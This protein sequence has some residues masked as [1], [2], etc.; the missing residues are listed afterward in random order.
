MRIYATTLNLRADQGMS[1]V[2]ETVQRWVR[3]KERP[4]AKTGA[5]AKPLRFHQRGDSSDDLDVTK[6][7]ARELPSGAYLEVLHVGA[8]DGTALHSIRYSHRDAKQHG[9]R[10]VTEIGVRAE[11]GVEELQVS[12]YLYT[13]DLSARV[14]E[15]VA[16][17]RPTLVRDMLARCLPMPG[18]P[19]LSLETLGLA[20]AEAFRSRVHDANR[21]AP[22][23]VL[24]PA[25]AGEYLVDP[26]ACLDQLAGLADVVCIPPDEDTRRIEE[27]IGGGL[28][29]YGGAAVILFTPRGGPYSTPVPSR[30]FLPGTIESDPSDAKVAVRSLFLAI[31]ERTNL[32]NSKKHISPERVREARLRQALNIRLRDDSSAVQ[33]RALILELQSEIGRQEEEVR[34]KD[35]EIAENEDSFYHICDQLEEIRKEKHV[36]EAKNAW[37]ESRISLASDSPSANAE[38]LPELRTAIARLAADEPT[39][40]QCLTLLQ[41]F[42]PDRVCVLQSAFDSADAS[43]GFRSGSRLWELLT[44]LAEQYWDALAS[45]R[46]DDEARKVFP[47]AKFA[48]RDKANL[49]KA[50]RQARTFIYKQQPLFMEPHL[51]VGNNGGSADTTL[52]VHFEWISE[53]GLIVIGHCGE[54]I[55]F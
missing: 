37:L 53:D 1:R 48:A 31:T 33:L 10:W 19:G 17:S 16:P 55:S 39:P 26:A 8:S 23:V 49:S 32:A 27:V 22:I 41:H 47:P 54:H 13:D 30:R 4:G 51:K 40:R 43:V 45:G 29:P 25:T 3:T 2:L 9:R 46:P 20:N 11:A 5:A 6:S 14:A 24:S 36:V 21:R 44:T 52:R 12:V 35:R 28:T 50:G 15:S 42:Y 18:T 34:A 38:G 7:G